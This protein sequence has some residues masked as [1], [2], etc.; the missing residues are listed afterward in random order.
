MPSGE[1]EVAKVAHRLTSFKVLCSGVI[2]GLKLT[3]VG[4]MKCHVHMHHCFDIIPNYVLHFVEK[5][6]GGQKLSI[7]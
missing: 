2:Q 5:K 3:N 1:Y 7:H 4:F 6:S